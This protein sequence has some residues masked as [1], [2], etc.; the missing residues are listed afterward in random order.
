MVCLTRRLQARDVPDTRLGHQGLGVEVDEVMMRF[1][2]LRESGPG[3][4]LMVAVK[5][6]RIVGSRWSVQGGL[7][8][9]VKV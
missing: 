1:G 7:K 6:G 9:P 8:Y 5:G 3:P 2:W 4:A